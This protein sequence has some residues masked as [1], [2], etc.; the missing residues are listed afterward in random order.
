MTSCLTAASISVTTRSCRLIPNNI[1]ICSFLTQMVPQVLVQALV[2]SCL[3]YSNPLL[4]GVSDPSYIQDMVKPY[5][6]AHPL[7]SATANQLATPPLWEGPSYHSA[8]L[9]F[10][11]DLKI[12][13][14][15]CTLVHK[16]LFLSIIVSKCGTWISST[17]LMKLMGCIHMFEC[18]YCMSFWT[19]A[20]VK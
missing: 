5:T 17:Y 11:T 9:S 15:D 16:K 20:S 14:S 6:P 2:I 1:R 7:H 8:N 4:A 13:Y 12:T 10:I 18:T 19:K 3:G